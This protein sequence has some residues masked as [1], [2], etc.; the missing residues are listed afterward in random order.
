MNMRV[1]DPR[2]DHG[3]AGIMHDGAARKI[4]ERGDR[5]DYTASDVNRG[6]ALSFGSYYSPSANN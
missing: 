3:I 2:H 6:R 5:R 1:N 4:I